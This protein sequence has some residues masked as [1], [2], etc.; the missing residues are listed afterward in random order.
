MSP[1][2]H[3]RKWRLE[4]IINLLKVTER[5]GVL[6]S[7][8]DDIKICVFAISPFMPQSRHKDSSISDWYILVQIWFYMLQAEI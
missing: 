5:Q 6:E 1:I 4:D 8:S 3:M 2:L 7:E